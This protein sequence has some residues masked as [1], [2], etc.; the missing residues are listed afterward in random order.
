[1]IY[2]LLSK[3]H[4]FSKIF[5]K[6]HWSVMGEL[7]ASLQKITQVLSIWYQTKH[8]SNCQNLQLDSPAH[9]EYLFGIRGL[10]E[11]KVISAYSQCGRNKVFYCDFFD[12]ENFFSD[13]TNRYWDKTTPW[14]TWQVMISA[15]SQIPSS[16]LVSVLRYGW[17]FKFLNLFALY[18]SR[19]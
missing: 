9:K 12:G 1:M 17:L 14:S 13:D 3:T 7:Y 15:I 2:D 16:W 10:N 4:H 18:K 11:T 6:M 8:C 5:V 19:Y